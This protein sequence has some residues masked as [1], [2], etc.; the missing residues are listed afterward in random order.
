M[1]KQAHGSETGHLTI[2]DIRLGLDVFF[3]V[4]Q[5]GGK[6]AKRFE[7]LLQVL[8]AC[9]ASNAECTP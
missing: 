8:Q 6:T 4:G 9:G 2:G 5:P 1:D 3:D 7:E